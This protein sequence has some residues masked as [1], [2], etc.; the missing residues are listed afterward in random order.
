VKPQYYI[1]EGVRRA[2]AALAAGRCDIAAKIILTGQQVD[3]LTR[4][5]LDQLHS[6]KTYILRDSRYI[7][8]TE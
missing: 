7:R 8:D 1:K 5:D 4:L 3:L 2:V 6:P